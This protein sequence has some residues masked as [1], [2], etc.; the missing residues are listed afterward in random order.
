MHRLPRAPRLRKEYANWPREA[1]I[2]S[3]IVMATV[4]LDPQTLERYR[5][6]L[7]YK[8]RYHLGRFCPDVDD[9]V[10]ETLAR[11]LQAD[12][13]ERI[14][15][16]E[17]IGAFLSGV[18]N[19]VIQEYRRRTWREP[20]SDSDLAPPER[21]A[22]AEP[23]LLEL[24]QTISL[25]MAELPTRD[26]EIL[27]AFYLEEKTKEEICNSMGL[28]DGQFRVALCRAKERFRRI[29]EASLKRKPPEGH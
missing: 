11:F 27:L 14:R 5:L 21:P 24:R 8:V 12:R 17:S 22:P 3:R 28:S 6:K 23:D 19:N 15:N 1:G 26:R 9:V 13:D 20:L 18:C 7:T 29:H 2:I 10:Q 16:P 4:N 25:A